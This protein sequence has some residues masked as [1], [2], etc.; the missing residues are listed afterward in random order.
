MADIKGS[1]VDVAFG[2][3]ASTSSHFAPKFTLMSAGVNV[4]KDYK[5]NFLGAHDAV[6]INVQRGNAK[7]GG[8]SRPIFESLVGRGI[9]DLKKVRVVAYS[10][11]IPQYPWVMRT[12]LKPDVQ[13]KVR[14]AFYGLKK[15][16]PEGDAVLKPFK[17]DGFAEIKDEDYN[18]IRDI[19][20]NVKPRS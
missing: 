20:S 5:E 11:P 3:P 19:R 10:K 2:D 7:V 13:K 14:S 9:I 16:T 17:S 18:I 8:L 15:G 12:D 1:G 6:A 4:G